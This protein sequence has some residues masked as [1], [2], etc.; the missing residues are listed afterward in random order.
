MKRN[1]MLAAALALGAALPAAA[2]ECAGFLPPNDMKIPVGSVHAKG[3]AE[4]QFNAVLDTIQK[5]Y[6]PELATIG[7]T[8]KINRRW[9][10][11]TVNASAQQSGKTYILNM[12][13]GLARHAAV[14]MDGFALV[15]C[16]EMG[17][18]IG[19][20]PKSS[21]ASIEGQADYY[22][23]LKCLRKVFADPSASAFTQPKGSAETARKA[24]EGA[25]KT[26]EDRGIC[27]RNAM[28]GQSV[29]DLFKA[30]TN[31]SVAPSYD[32]PDTTVVTTMMTKHPPTQCRLDTYLQASICQQP[33]SAAVSNTNVAAGTCTRSGGFPTGYRPL[34]WYKP[35]NAAELL[36]PGSRTLD[37]DLGGELPEIGP[38]FDSLN[39]GFQ[40]N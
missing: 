36:P 34:C 28:A 5:I 40:V 16:H 39:S 21:W 8:L 12:Y 11:E 2:S 18:H 24:C 22:A 26:A 13:G 23:N 27:V 6:G 30:L 3:I 35:A 25:F 7:A 32:T 38:A 9:T 37:F 15:A 17:H 14:T 19:G 10:D 4:A 29:A 33:V 31:S 1:L 20:A